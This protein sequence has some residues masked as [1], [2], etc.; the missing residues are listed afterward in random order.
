[1]WYQ[2]WHLTPSGP[3]VVLPAHLSTNPDTYTVPIMTVLRPWGLSTAHDEIRF[4]RISQFVDRYVFRPAWEQQRGRNHAAL[5][6]AWIDNSVSHV[7]VD[8]SMYTV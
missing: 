7:H 4:P 2:M 6:F 8:V 1:M 3:P 5:S